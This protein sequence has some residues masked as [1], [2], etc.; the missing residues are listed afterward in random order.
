MGESKVVDGQAGKVPCLNCGNSEWPEKLSGGSIG[1]ERT[2]EGVPA[3]WCRRCVFEAIVSREP[4]DAHDAERLRK[5]QERHERK[6]E[7]GG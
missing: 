1:N 5:A 3:G 7:Q 6:K 2:G 4:A